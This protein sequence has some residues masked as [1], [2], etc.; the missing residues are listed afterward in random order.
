MNVTRA[1]KVRLG[2]FV[3]VSL[4]LLL[5]TLVMLAGLRFTD[6]RDTYLVRFPDS[7]S[8]LE[9]GAQVKYSGVRVGRVESV[10]INPDDVSEVLVSVSLERGTPI[11]TDTVAVL[12]LAGITG[13]KFIELTGGSRES[14]F[15]EP[16]GE[17]QA[18]ASLLDRLSGQAEEIAT[19][20]EM[21][22]NSMNLMFS[23]ENRARISAILDNLEQGTAVAVA[24]ADD[25]RESLRLTME[26]V[27]EVS[28]AL[29]PAIENL[30][31]EAQATLVAITD[32]ATALGRTI[33]RAR[34]ERVSNQ[35]E[36]LLV[37]AHRKIRDTDVEGLVG[38]MNQ[39]VAHAD[40]LVTSLNVTVLRSRE[41]LYGSLS[42]LLEG[43]ENFS[44]F[45]RM[46][47]ENPSLLLSGRAAEERVLR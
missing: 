46:V 20:V 5:L 16:G 30:D 22:L 28:A 6:V 14:G 39:L 37:T 12:N 33:E 25:N 43:M 2:V 10:R 4:T 13:L 44:D 3:V 9:V 31:R 24:M 21:L 29:V 41:D 40:Q 27:A 23:E 47:R 42:Y 8:G 36:R 38:I 35:A 1:Q 45:A 19:K 18:G 32:S 17:I 11:K 7:V 26:N 15:I 34:I